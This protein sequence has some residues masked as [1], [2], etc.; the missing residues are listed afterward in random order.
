M[1]AVDEFKAYPISVFSIG[2]N[3]GSPSYC[4]WLEACILSTSAV[5][6]IWASRTASFAG[7]VPATL[8]RT[9][10]RSDPGGI[11]AK[12]AGSL[13]DDILDH[14]PFSFRAV[15]HLPEMSI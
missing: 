11:R 12:S 13:S 9:S 1:I 7:T 4:T 2:S 3:C 5:C 8:A 6:G 14:G 15:Y 10:S